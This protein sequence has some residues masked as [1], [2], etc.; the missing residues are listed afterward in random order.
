MTG[1]ERKTE[2]EEEEEDG[3][4]KSGAQEFRSSGVLEFWP[5][6]FRSAMVLLRFGNELEGRRLYLL[7]VRLTG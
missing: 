6:C 3:S 1:Q 2:E 5:E 7:S 4:Q